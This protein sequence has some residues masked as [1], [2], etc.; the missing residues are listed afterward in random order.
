MSERERESASK[1]I[2]RTGTTWLWCWKW[3][4][5]ELR[6]ERH[7][8]HIRTIQ[9][10]KHTM[11]IL[12][13]SLFHSSNWAPVHIKNKYTKL[14]IYLFTHL[15]LDTSSLLC[16]YVRVWCVCE[17]VHFVVCKTLLFHAKLRYWYTFHML[18]I[19]K[20]WCEIDDTE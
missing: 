4:G 20:S 11:K 3:L 5:K 6:D 14:P 18:M 13:S 8:T 2:K 7:K 10:N 19:R 12:S 16:F 15:F 17:L 1:K 9:T